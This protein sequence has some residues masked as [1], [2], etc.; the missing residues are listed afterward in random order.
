MHDVENTE[1]AGDVRRPRYWTA[2]A[3]SWICYY[4]WCDHSIHNLDM[5]WERLWQTCGGGDDDLVLRDL[6]GAIKDEVQGG[7]MKVGHRAARVEE[8][9]AWKVPPSLLRDVERTIYT[10]A[11]AAGGRWW[12]MN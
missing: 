7:Q 6:C 1:T 9:A 12:S 8:R 10:N 5:D 2:G 4:K 3:A 11:S